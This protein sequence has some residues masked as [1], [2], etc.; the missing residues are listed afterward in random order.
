M[1]AYTLGTVVRAIL[2][3][4]GGPYLLVAIIALGGIGWLWKDLRAER[5]ERAKFYAEKDAEAARQI[6]HERQTHTSY[7]QQ[8]INNFEDREKASTAEL[9][10]IAEALDIVVNTSKA[11][12]LEM[13]QRI[14]GVK[15]AVYSTR[16]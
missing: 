11:H 16:K 15:D 14:D 8:L 5:R 6:A 2:Q 10:K 1:D 3:A 9:R 4:G 7:L 12:Q 13:L